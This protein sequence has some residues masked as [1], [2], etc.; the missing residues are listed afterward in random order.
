MNRMHLAAAFESG[1]MAAAAA[2]SSS[3]VRPQAEA[4]PSSAC[5]RNQEG[6]RVVLLSSTKRAPTNDY[7]WVTA[8]IHHIDPHVVYEKAGTLHEGTALYM[9]EVGGWGEEFKVVV[10]HQTNPDTHTNP[11]PPVVWNVS[12]KAPAGFGEDLLA[13]LCSFMTPRELSAIF[14]PPRSADSL[15]ASSSALPST[16]AG[17]LF[18][19]AAFGPLKGQTTA[20][21][22]EDTADGAP[23]GAASLLSLFGG[24]SLIGTSTGQGGLSSAAAAA[25]SGG[26]PSSLLFTVGAATPAVK[27]RSRA[28]RI[29]AAPSPA[30]AAG[31]TNTIIAPGDL[32]GGSI[33]APAKAPSKLPPSAAQSTT[34][35]TS[36]PFELGKAST[37]KGGGD[38]LGGGAAASG[39][40]FSGTGRGSLSGQGGAATG[41][42]G[43]F[44]P[45]S[46]SIISG[47]TA[48]VA[49][50]SF[51]G[52][53][54]SARGGMFGGAAFGQQS[55]FGA[56][57]SSLSPI[58]TAA[59]HQ[60][61]H[62]TIDCSDEDDRY[63][64]E[65]M[66]PEQAFQLGKRLVNL[67]AITLVQPRGDRLWCLDTMMSVVEGHAAGR[68]EVCEKKGQQHMPKGS[69]ETIHFTT[70]DSQ[71]LNSTRPSPP[72]RL[73]PPAPPPTLH[74]LSPTL[75]SLR[76]VTGAVRH[77]SVLAHKGWCMPA[78]EYVDQDGWDA[79][80]LGQFISSSSSLKEVGGRRR[81][82]DEWAGVFEHF[83]ITPAGQPGPLR[84]LE[85]IGGIEWF[86]GDEWGVRRLQDVLT[87]R[88]CRKS[89]RRLDVEVCP[90]DFDDS[91]SALLAV[92]GFI[93]TCC[94]SPDVPLT[95]TV[96][97][98]TAFELALFYAVEFPPRPSPF[99]KTA[100]QEAARQADEVYWNFL[101]EHDITHPLNSPSE[102][103]IE[104]AQSLTFAKVEWVSVHNA[105]G[106][107]PPPGTTPPIP[108]IINH[109]PPFPRA[110]ELRVHSGLVAAAAGRLLA[111]KMPREVLRVEFGR[112]VSAE[113]RRGVL[114]GLGE[115]GGLHT[116]RVGVELGEVRAVSLTQGGAFDG[117]GSSRLPSIREIRMYLEVSDELEPLAAAELIRSGLSTLLTAGVRG[118]RRVGVLLLMHGGLHDAIRQLLPNTRIGDFSISTTDD[119]GDIVVQAKLSGR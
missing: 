20:A 95:V 96:V 49:S 34:T 31:L 92:D 16:T 100:I 64:W 30:S 93:N 38:L 65:S 67:T 103:A 51:S 70:A 33:F 76:T 101:S 23:P 46:G 42:G 98:D 73:P 62:I 116:V 39:G 55:S 115:G 74:A 41:T 109:L 94:T 111:E 85:R 26:G 25:S 71:L 9:R 43:I 15:M 58:H 52:P 50:N 104:I 72:S 40:T 28:K 60:Q 37:G 82:W 90:F 19:G 97:C 105:D 99:I 14:P 3:S 119:N 8:S 44:G 79:D 84:H 22:K 56:T 4:M 102:A 45:F 21:A 57:Q 81:T 13:S 17:P 29:S 18:A 6:T 11:Q 12:K 47:G 86:R 36:G 32:F 24:Q 113:D 91:L 68:R 78:L 10:P 66:T 108:T 107:V 7:V 5:S 69:L 110:R 27:P 87:S 53:S 80:E 114:E 83:P 2:A 75:H 1:P 61:T 89:L 117:W 88:G 48:V 118:L 106:F 59:L 112:G 63:F 54:F 35:P 77:H